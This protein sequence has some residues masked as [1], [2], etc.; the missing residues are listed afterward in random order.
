VPRTTGQPGKALTS[1]RITRHRVGRCQAHGPHLA[2]SRRSIHQAHTS[3]PRSVGG[4]GCCMHLGSLSPRQNASAAAGVTGEDLL[5]ESRL[6]TRADFCS[7]ALAA[8]SATDGRLARPHQT[9]PQC[10]RS[11]SAAPDPAR[12]KAI[13]GTPVLRTLAASLLLSDSGRGEQRSEDPRRGS[14]GHK[15]APRSATCSPRAINM[16]SARSAPAPASSSQERRTHPKPGTQLI[17]IP[18]ALAAPRVGSGGTRVHLTLDAAG[19]NAKRDLPTTRAGRHGYLRTR[20]R[21]VGES[22]SGC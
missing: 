19:L 9:L 11:E 7:V 6:E 17:W 3:S 5:R 13:L 2:R 15:A 8:C 14:F 4:L 18:L 21:R 16:L 20:G 12:T 22:P 10:R 1:A